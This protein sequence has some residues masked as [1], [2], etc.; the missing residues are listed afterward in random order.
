MTNLILIARKRREHLTPEQ[1]QEQEQL[2]R[3]VES[4]QISESD[5]SKLVSPLP[6]ERGGAG[7]VENVGRSARVTSPS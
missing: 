7:R 5:L 6:L 4:G 3:K 2:R 1:I